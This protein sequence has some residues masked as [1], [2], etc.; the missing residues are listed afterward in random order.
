MSDTRAPRATHRLTV[1]AAITTSNATGN[2]RLTSIA[3]AV[4]FMLLAAEGVTIIR[5]NSHLGAHMFIGMILVPVV[6][7]KMLSTGYRFI[8]YY[9]GDADYVAKGAPRSVLRIAGPF[10]VVLTIAVLATG[11]ALGIAGPR[12]HELL[13]LHKASF[14]LWFVAMTIHVLGHLLETPRL[15]LADWTA[16]PVVAGRVTR[17]LLIVVALIG[18]LALAFATR[19]WS[20]QWRPL[21]LGF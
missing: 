17:V 8:R 21:R 4:L 16:A 12:H 3:G 6:A 10:V 18:G 19:S 15:A 2:A 7:L 1:T 11:I 13:Q 14:V 5:V 9:T 20:A